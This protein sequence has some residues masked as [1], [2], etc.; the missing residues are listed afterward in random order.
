MARE[1]R[2]QKAVSKQSPEKARERTHW[3]KVLSPPPVVFSHSPTC[4][5]ELGSMGCLL[6]RHSDVCKL[7]EQARQRDTGC[8]YEE[9][10][11]AAGFLLDLHTCAG[12]GRREEKTL[13]PKERCLLNHMRMFAICCCIS[14]HCHGCE[15]GLASPF[16][17]LICSH[18]QG[19]L[20]AMQISPKQLHEQVMILRGHG[21]KLSS[22]RHC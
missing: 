19:H 2:E 4:W 5:G 12:R 21:N 15:G 20:S 18:G 10:R 14:E 7:P 13:R 6:S 3:P 1:G 9:F 11:R 17:W 8:Y 16:S 22:K